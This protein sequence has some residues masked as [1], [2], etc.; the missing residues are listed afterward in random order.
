MILGI[1]LIGLGVLALAYQRFSYKEREKIVDVG[2][3]QA[4][5]ER[6]KTVPIPPIIGGAL[7]IGGVVLLVYGL[8][9]S[10]GRT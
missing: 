10:P 8:R 1:V 9:R 5:A 2:P 6:E 3:L 7:V 4:T